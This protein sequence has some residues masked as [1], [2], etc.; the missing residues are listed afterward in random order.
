VSVD[1]VYVDKASAQVRAAQTRDEETPPDIAVVGEPEGS[2]LDQLSE[3]SRLRF[4]E[5][6]ARLSSLSLL[7]ADSVEPDPEYWMKFEIAPEYAGKKLLEDQRQHGQAN[8]ALFRQ[9]I[10]EHE[11]ELIEAVPDGEEVRYASNHC[12]PSA[13]S[14]GAKRV[15]FVGSKLNPATVSD[16]VFRNSTRGTLDQIQPENMGVFSVIDVRWAFNLIPIHPDHRKYTTFWGPDGKF[17]RYRRMSFGF[18]NAPAVFHRWMTDLFRPLAEFV[19]VFVD[20]LLIFS[21][22]PED[23]VRHLDDVKTLLV[24]HRIPV[25][26]QKLKLFRSQVDYLGTRVG[27]G[28]RIVP[29]AASL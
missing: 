16:P 23:H 15:S 13:A 2:L 29:N 4:A 14:G 26:W 17:Y 10:E 27:P 20:D 11:G 19:R 5:V 25:R 22:N 21:A 6:Q 8:D 7:S 1:R 18:K 12:F 3:T 9:W 28:N 24:K